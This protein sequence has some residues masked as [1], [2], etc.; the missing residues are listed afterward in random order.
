M[1]KVL[2]ISPNNWDWIKQRPQFIAEELTAYYDV[3]VLHPAKS[4]RLAYKSS[5]YDNRIEH[6]SEVRWIPI[7]GRYKKTRFIN[8]WIWKHAISKKFLEKKYDFIYLTS[9]RQV[10]FLPAQIESEIIYDCMDNYIELTEGEEEKQYTDKCQKAIIERARYT[11]ASSD[12]L[13]KYLRNK[14]NVSNV[15]VVRNAFNNENRRSL[16][17]EGNDKTTSKSDRKVFM[18][19]GTVSWWFDFEFILRSL[20]D[21]PDIEYWIAGPLHGVTIPDNE[22]IKYL[23]VIAHSEL[24]DT[25]VKSDCLIMPFKINELILAVDPV[26]LYEYID[27]HKNILCVEYPEIERFRDFVYFYTDYES[28]KAQIEI[29]SKSKYV[30]YTNEQRKAFLGQNTWKSRAAEISMIIEEK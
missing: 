29:V 16:S 23:G 26:K 7:V 4:A 10:E 30:K 9:P 20:K 13:A 21:F 1:K 12:H 24:E 17:D 5:P 28:Y 25:V 19:I 11:I 3:E 22:R 6:I 18:Y 14:Y 8:E 15:Y 27:F 2:Y